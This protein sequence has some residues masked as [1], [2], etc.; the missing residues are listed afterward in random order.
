MIGNKKNLNATGLNTMQGNVLAA[1]RKG[2]LTG[3]DANVGSAGLTMTTKAI[4]TTTAARITITIT[5]STL[6]TAP[7]HQH[8]HLL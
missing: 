6:Q 8:P 5:S 3:H 4:A 7:I 2:M 1:F